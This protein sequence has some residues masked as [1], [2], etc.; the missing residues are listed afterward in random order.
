MRDAHPDTVTD[1]AIRFAD[2]AEEA[3]DGGSLPE[4]H[5]I[6]TRLYPPVGEVLERYDALL[7]STC[8]TRGLGDG[9]VD[10]G[11][12]VDGVELPFY[13]ETMLTV[14][15]NILSRCPVL[16]VPSGFAANGIPTGVQIVGRTYDDL[17]P[18]QVGR[19]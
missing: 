2:W 17:T 10:H 5:E 12:E 6:E 9:Y 15:F 13:F 19:R 3:A 4:Q 7:C 16:N 8:G 11:L 18:F 14:V 1:Y